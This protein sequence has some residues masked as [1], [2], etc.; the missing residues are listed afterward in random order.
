MKRKILTLAL[1]LALICG[2]ALPVRAEEPVGYVT[3][4]NGFTISLYPTEEEKKALGQTLMEQG[5][6][7]LYKDAKANGRY[8]DPEYYAA[9]NPD[10]V[11]AFGDEPWVFYYHYCEYGINENRLPYEGATPGEGRA[12]WEMTRLRVVIKMLARQA[13]ISEEEEWRQ[14]YGDA[15]PWYAT[16]D[17]IEAKIAEQG[18]F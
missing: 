15:I 9:H 8:F 12:N 10:V 5:I 7:S 2:I 1:S 3:D 11:A 17:G 4:A 14:S 13:G 6:I 16:N 18:G